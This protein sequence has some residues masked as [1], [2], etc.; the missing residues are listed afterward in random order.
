[1]QTK[2]TSILVIIIVLLVISAPLAI[3]SCYLKLSGYTPKEKT[4][5][6]EPSKEDNSTIKKP[7]NDSKYA[8]GKLYFYDL[9]KNLIGE[10]TCEKDPCSYAVSN[11]TDDDYPIAYLKSEE[12][13]INPYNNYAFI[14]D[15]NKILIYNFQTKE[16]VKTYQTI[17]N[18]HNMLEG[19]MIVQD[20]NNKW[21]VIKLDEV[22]TEII[23][24]EYDFI[25]LSDSLNEDNMLNNENFIVLKDNLWAI[26]D[27]E[28]DLA[29]NFLSLPI[30]SYNDLLI[31]VENDNIYY[32]YDYNG[33]RVVD[34]SGFN[35]L[36]FT[37]KYINIIDHNN[38]LYI[39][40]YMN[41]SKISPNMKINNSDDYR[42]SFTSTYN[43]ETKSIDVVIDGRE[44]NYNVE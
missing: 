15:N 43:A 31:S 2:K 4:E 9:N 5:E 3:L 10:Y 18:Y 13:D 8:N 32:L 27:N 7:N 24:L 22:I 35:Y 26:I 29:S 21:G 20:E 41:D 42:N 16:V 30:T 17:K 19:Y 11:I 44:Y 14:N 39:Y 38:N 25:G 33:K 36:S 28:G 23:P 40:D 12:T 1:M 6:K 37:D 34:E